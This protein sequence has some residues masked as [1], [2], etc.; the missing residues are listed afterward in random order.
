M[1]K[2]IGTFFVTQEMYHPPHGGM[3][4]QTQ[5]SILGQDRAELYQESD[6]KLE[7]PG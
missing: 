5:M 1:A 4:L 7:T 2:N 3:I 6:K